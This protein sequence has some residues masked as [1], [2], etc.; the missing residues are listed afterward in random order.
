M[1][2]LHGGSVERALWCR[3]V[4][5]VAVVAAVV[6]EWSGASTGKVAAASRYMATN[7]AEYGWTS[8][9]TRGNANLG[10]ETE[11]DLNS[12]TTV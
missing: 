12:V 5:V 7:L 6:V 1:Q 2:R 11:L 3:C 4:V 9:G 10:D 8:T